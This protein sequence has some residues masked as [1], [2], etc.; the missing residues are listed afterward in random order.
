MASMICAFILKKLLNGTLSYCLCHRLSLFMF[1]N[2]LFKLVAPPLCTIVFCC[3]KALHV[4][5]YYVYLCM[6]V[7]FCQSVL[8]FSVSKQNSVI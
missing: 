4:F 5:F 1:R 7:L 6:H 3:E 2:W 8:L